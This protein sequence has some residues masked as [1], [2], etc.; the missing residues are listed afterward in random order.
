MHATDAIPP[1]SISSE[2]VKPRPAKRPKEP[3]GVSSPKKVPKLPKK[4]KRENDDLIKLLNGGDSFTKAVVLHS[5]AEGQ[6]LSNPVD[7]KDH[8]AK[9]GMNRYMTIKWTVIMPL[10]TAEVGHWRPW[11]GSQVPTTY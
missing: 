8:W 6:D 2:T 1:S 5:T 10:G 11:Q 3:K 9:H 4:V 7:L